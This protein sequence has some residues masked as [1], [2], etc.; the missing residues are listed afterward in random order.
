MAQ[1]LRENTSLADD[2][3]SISGTHVGWLITNHLCCKSSSWGSDAIF[4]LLQILHIYGTHKNKHAHTCIEIEIKLIKCANKIKK[5]KKIIVNCEIYIQRQ[6]TSFLGGARSRNSQ[7]K[8]IYQT[9]QS[10][11][12]RVSKFESKSI[13]NDK[14]LDE[15]N[16]F[17][18]FFPHMIHMI[19]DTKYIT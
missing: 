4:W 18:S 9:C 2:W 12:G 8:E 16:R 14:Y 11:F 15:H 19:G 17:L 5:L 6:V 13:K 3:S 10:T 7:R 1:Q